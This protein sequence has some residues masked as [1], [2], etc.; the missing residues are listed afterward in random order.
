MPLL[1]LLGR[2]RI[3]TTY[4]YICHCCCVCAAV[5]LSVDHPVTAASGGGGCCCCCCCCVWRLLMSRLEVAAAAVSRLSG[6]SGRGLDEEVGT[7]RRGWARTDVDRPRRTWS[8]VKG[9]HGWMG[10]RERH[11]GL[12]E[13]VHAVWLAGW[14][15]GSDVDRSWRT[16]L[17]GHRRT[18]LVLFLR[19]PGS[20]TGI[21]R[22]WTS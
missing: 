10:I 16:R 8:P 4:Y 15:V 18:R 22:L 12:E 9:G 1:S 17:A 11:S 5:L 7:F 20:G 3:P 6:S 2:R 19:V 21:G 13:D 14:L